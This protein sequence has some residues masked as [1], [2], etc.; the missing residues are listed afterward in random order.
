MA[1]GPAAMVTRGLRVALARRD[2]LHALSMEVRFGEVL[3]VVG[4]NGAGKSTLLRT[5]AGLLPYRGTVVVEGAELVSLSSV[6]RARRVS[7]VPQQSS[8]TAALSVREVVTLG[9]YVH[10]PALS[11]LREVD[12]LAIDAALRH[13]D[14]LALAE[15]AFSDL[16]TGEQKRVLLARALCTE[17]RILLLDEP[18]GSLDIEHA[19]RLFALLRG[20]ATT[21][22]AI[23]VVLHQ[24][25][26]ALAFAHRALLLQRGAELACGDAREVLSA[27][28]VRTLHGVTMISGGA[29]SF[30]LPDEAP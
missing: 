1:E 24:L 28:H 5:L 20:L 14:V 7:F 4:P 12:H 11:R 27:E 17:A 15:R 22:H 10:R 13:T 16:S 6:E 29:P 19:L 26:H 30:V 8:L 21:G 18:T 3:A 9:R 25:E 2:V 23:V